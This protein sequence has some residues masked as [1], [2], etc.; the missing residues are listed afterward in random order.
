MNR[1][2]KEIAEN[3]DILE[4]AAIDITPAA[5]EYI[6]NSRKPNITAWSILIAWQYPTTRKKY[7]LKRPGV[8]FFFWN[9]DTR[10]GDFF[11][12]TRRNSKERF[13]LHKLD[14]EPARFFFDY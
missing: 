11:A 6:Q 12:M 2:I 5:A 1:P 4:A 10:A 3:V 7:T 13:L 9:E 8:V 14:H